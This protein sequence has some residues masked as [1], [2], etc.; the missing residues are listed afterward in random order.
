MGVVALDHVPALIG[1]RLEANGST[2]AGAAAFAVALLVRRLRDD[3]FDA[4]GAQV[5]ADRPG[6][7]GLVA[8]H[9]LRAGPRPSHRTGHAQ[10]FLERK[11]HGR[12]SCLAWG[13]QA[14]QRESRTVDELMDRRAQPAPGA[15]YSMIG[16]LIPQIRVVRSSPL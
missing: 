7:V 4:S 6:G 11:Q 14:D 16:G 12:V 8:Q 1:R 9:R 3:S 13:D 15:S 2:A 10:L 5:G